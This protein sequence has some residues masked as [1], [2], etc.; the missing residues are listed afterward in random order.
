MR[1][2][3]KRRGNSWVLRKQVGGQRRDYPLGVY[4]GEE[5]RAAA[6][7]AA[8]IREAQ[9]MEAH[10]ASSVLKKFGLTPP[11]QVNDTLT[12]AGWW[13]E[14]A[15]HYLPEKAATTQKRDREIMAK[16]LPLLGGMPMGAVRQKHCLAALQERRKAFAGQDTRKVKT[17]ITENTVQ[18]DRRLLQAV[19]QR[20]VEN[21]VIAKNPWKGIESRPDTSRSD[22]IL[23]EEDEVKLMAAL[24]ASRP[25]ATGQLVRVDPRY[26][27]FITFMLQT[28][29]RLDE[30]L[31]THFQD[32]GSHIRVRGKGSK[33]RDV[34]LTK[35]ART[36]LDEQVAA[37]GRRWWQIPQR[38]RHVMMVGCQRAEIR[39][40]GPHDL[41]HT[42][43]ARYLQRGG[44]IY[45]L[46][47]LLGH[48]S[49]AVTEKHYS[50]MRQEDIA[51]RMLAI[52]EV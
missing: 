42:F 47:K 19:F 2:Q 27:R 5:Q 44:D 13:E 35:K 7:A 9:V 12:L 14:Y 52:M 1:G 33:W 30:L 49:V 6:M 8:A 26:G 3:V 25:S 36:T 45:V 32:C 43:G 51:A 17:V 24:A 46:S 18:R 40:L 22:R 41:R 48:A 34:P 50:F 31:N 37:D 23:T 4:G 11:K 39:H 28:G 21:E 16:W 38:F 29:L 15:R 20:A 10:A